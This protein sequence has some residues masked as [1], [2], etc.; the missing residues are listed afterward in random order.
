MPG[1]PTEGQK[2]QRINIPVAVL[3]I[4]TAFLFDAVQDVA[5]FANVVPG[6]GTAVAFIVSEF[7]AWLAA[8]VFFIWFSLLGVRY[9]DKNFA[10]K[11]LLSMAAFVVELI[12]LLDILPAITLDVVVLVVLT[13]IEDTASSVPGGAAAAALLMNSAS[14]S[15]SQRQQQNNGFKGPGSASYHAPKA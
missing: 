14:S 12:P 11:L 13:R 10:L 8:A 15:Q 1:A 2:K 4:G 7:I 9:S 3:L 5:F 6:I